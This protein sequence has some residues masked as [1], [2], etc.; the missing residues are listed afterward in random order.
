MKQRTRKVYRD[1]DAANLRAARIILADRSRYDNSA[2]RYI[3]RWAKQV[4]ARLDP[5]RQPGPEKQ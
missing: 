4:L 3:I 2:E 1:P 5:N